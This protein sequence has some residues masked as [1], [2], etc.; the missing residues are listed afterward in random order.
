MRISDVSSPVANINLNFDTLVA[1]CYHGDYDQVA[2]D[3]EVA[4][5]I[6]SD[7]R[8]ITASGPNP[9]VYYDSLALGVGPEP[10]GGTV[11]GQLGVQA[12]CKNNTTGQAVTI[13]LSGAKSWDCEAAGL[14]VNPGDIIIQLPVGIAE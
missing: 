8:R 4:H 12:I 5:I 2:V 11:T 14:V 10:V 13:L 7:D 3:T 6:W 1:R 9:D